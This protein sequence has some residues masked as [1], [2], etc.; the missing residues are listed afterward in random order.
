MSESPVFD[1]STSANGTNGDHTGHDQRGRFAKGNAGGPG[2]PFGRQVAALRGALMSCITNEDIQEVVVAL[3]A[4]AKKGNVAAARLILTYSVGK[5][6][7]TVDSDQAEV[8]ECQ[9]IPESVAPPAEIRQVQLANT[10]AQAAFQAIGDGL[11]D[12]LA[13]AGGDSAGATAAVEGKR[14]RGNRKL[15]KQQARLARRLLQAAARTGAT[16]S[17]PVPEAPQ[18]PPAAADGIAAASRQQSAFD[19]KKPPH[20]AVSHGV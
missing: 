12:L 5:P 9:R 7:S 16:A 19:G 17:T 18:R 3:L 14:R 2:N 15:R 10:P 11:A 4:Q 20:P 8:D 6:A 1:R 13:A